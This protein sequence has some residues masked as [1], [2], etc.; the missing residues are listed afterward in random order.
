MLIKKPSKIKSSEITDQELYKKRR[1][2]IQTGVGLAGAA[3]V[4]GLWLPGDVHAAREKLQGVKKSALSTSEKPTS[5]KDVTSYNNFYEFG[6][7]KSDPA[8]NAHT[9]K[10]EPWTVRVEGEVA[11]PADYHDLFVSWQFSDPAFQLIKGYQR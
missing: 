6:T 3:M 11:R 8:R 1:Q 9:L 2:F 5:Y 4:P 7:D 10:T